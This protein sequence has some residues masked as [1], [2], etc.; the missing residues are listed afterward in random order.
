[1]HFSTAVNVS[2]LIITSR[3]AAWSIS[4][5]GMSR[6]S[7]SVPEFTAM[8]NPLWLNRTWACIL[9]SAAVMVAL[10]KIALGVFEIV[11]SSLI[12][13]K[14]PHDALHGRRLVGWG[15]TFKRLH[16]ALNLADVDDPN[17]DLT[18]VDEPIPD[19]SEI[20]AIETF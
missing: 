6:S 2:L 15:G 17:T 20:V 10:C 16:K 1:M 8:S 3:S 13:G 9:A 5:Q 11:S 14:A 19:E 18:K 7:D 12:F 4:S